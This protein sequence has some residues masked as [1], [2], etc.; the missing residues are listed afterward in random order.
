MCTVF[1]MVINIW[2]ERMV[3]DD[4]CKELKKAFVP[5]MLLLVQS[6]Q[7][8]NVGTIVMMGIFVLLACFLV[9]KRA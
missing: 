7:M 5:I 9:H 4:G 2:E 8:I 1:D 3:K 6:F